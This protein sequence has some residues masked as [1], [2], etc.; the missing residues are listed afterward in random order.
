MNQLRLYPFHTPR[1]IQA[2]FP[3]R[4]WRVPSGEPVLYLSFDDGPMP[5]VTDRVLKILSAYKARATFFCTGRNAALHPEM[6]ER[7]KEQG[8]GFGNHGYNHLNGRKHSDAAYVEDVHRASEQV[9]GKL[10]RPPYGRLRAKQAK[11]LRSH[12]RI[13]MWD[14]LSGDFDPRNDGRTCAEKVIRHSRAGS[15]LLFHDSEK[16]RERV[17]EALPRVLEHFALRGFS[18]APLPGSKG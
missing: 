2:C 1:L 10:F 9:P 8:H 15:L 6:M 11:A 4:L 5:E 18:F 16:A 12:F 3:Q 7:I 13:V 14:V 17:L